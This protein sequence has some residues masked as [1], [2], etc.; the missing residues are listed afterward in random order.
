MQEFI[1]RRS[2]R[3]RVQDALDLENARRIIETYDD[4]HL[5]VRH[6]LHRGISADV[7]SEVLNE[8]GVQATVFDG[9]IS[10]QIEIDIPRGAGYK[11]GG[12]YFQENIPMLVFVLQEEDG[13]ETP[14]IMPWMLVVDS[15]NK[16]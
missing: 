10:G 15:Q 13:R 14:L 8:K 7:V 1:D 3:Q 6:M 2:Q 12:D 11:R 4:L 16:K 9:R 5:A